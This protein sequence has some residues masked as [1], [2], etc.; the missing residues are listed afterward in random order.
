MLVSARDLVLRMPS[1]DER[2]IRVGMSGNLCRCTGYVGIVRAVR[3]VIEARRRRGVAPVV[4]AGRT[5]FGPVGSR[6][7]GMLASSAQVTAGITVGEPPATSAAGIS[8]ED[9]SPEHVFGQDF[10]VP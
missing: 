6:H 5:L 7:S 8:I 9:F 1:A 10:V 3:S 2:D 4:G